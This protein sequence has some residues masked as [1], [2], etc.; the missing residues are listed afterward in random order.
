MS[1]LYPSK[2]DVR[3]RRLLVGGASVLLTGIV[4]TGFL[5]ESR[6]GYMKPD[7]KIIFMQNWRADRTRAETLADARATEAVQQAKIAEARAFAA[8][9]TG[10]ARAKALE[11]IDKYVTGG[12]AQKE[13]PYVRAPGRDAPLVSVPAASAP[14]VTTEPPVL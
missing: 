3:R 1:F 7:V 14:I 11:Q 13:I 4:M 6:S 8:T 5:M 9:L 2:T 10:P 12:G